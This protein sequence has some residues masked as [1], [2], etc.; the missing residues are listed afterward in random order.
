MLHLSQTQ[1]VII[2]SRRK[3]RSISLYRVYVN[4]KVN[5]NITLNVGGIEEKQKLPYFIGNSCAANQRRYA[6]ILI[7]FSAIY[8]RFSST[9]FVRANYT[10][11]NA[12]FL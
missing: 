9:L 11:E 10:F 6:M 12:N 5:E 3:S 8:Q 7:F 4:H 2:N 1:N